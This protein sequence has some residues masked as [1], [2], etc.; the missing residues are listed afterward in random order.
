MATI[1]MGSYMVRYPLG[2][3]LSWA[4]QYLTGFK[5]LGHDIYFVEKH[6]YE[7]SCFDPVKQIMTNDCATG[8]KIVSELLDRFGLG[9]KWCYVGEGDTY[10][11]LSK[12][13]IEA[14]FQK[15]DL[16]IENGAHEAWN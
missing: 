3:N 5:D 6:V 4:L 15:A 14:V 1:I 12:K 11:G 9:D 7:D 13:E 2:G 8:V 10:Y 16:Y